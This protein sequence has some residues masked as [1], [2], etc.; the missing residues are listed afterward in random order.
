MSGIILEELPRES[1]EVLLNA[2]DYGVDGE[3]FIINQNG[4]RIPSQENLTR[5][6]HIDEV[7]LVPG[8]LDVL[9]GTPTA[10]AKYLREQVEPAV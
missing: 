6:I 1:R 8:S 10:V 5:G 7:L 2:F 9:D 4:K 3:G